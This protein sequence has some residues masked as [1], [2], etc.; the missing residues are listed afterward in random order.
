MAISHGCCNHCA[1]SSFSWVE[2]KA[3]ESWCR[4]KTFSWRAIQSLY[5]LP[6]SST[7][8]SSINTLLIFCIFFSSCFHGRCSICH[9]CLF[10]I[11]QALLC[12]ILLELRPS[13][14]AFFLI[15]TSST[16]PSW[17][18]VSVSSCSD[19]PSCFCYRVS[20]HSHSVLLLIVRMYLNMNTMQ[21]YVTD[22]CDADNTLSLATHSCTETQENSIQSK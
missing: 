14:F 13:F 3:T 2:Y 17:S 1:S 10:L 4:S 21:G 20:P 15:S 22:I 11:L 6:T 18:S 8:T 9:I 19:I 12:L 16:Y 5:Y 7:E